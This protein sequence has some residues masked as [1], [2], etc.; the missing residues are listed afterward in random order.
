MKAGILISVVAIFV[1]FLVASLGS[2]RELRNNF[3]FTMPPDSAK[4]FSVS[5]P[6]DINLY[7]EDRITINTTTDAETNIKYIEVSASPENQ[8]T[9]PLC[10]F[11]FGRKEGDFSNYTILLDSGK[12]NTEEI[13]GGFCILA[14]REGTATGR[15]PANICDFIIMDEKLFD[16]FFQYGDRTP[17]KKETPGK[18]PVRAYSQN[19]LDLE[20]TIE[21]NVDIQPK[22]QLIRLEAGKWTT[23]EF[24]AP[25]LKQGNYN[26]ELI[27]E[28]VVN[29]TFCDSKRL[30]FCKKQISSTLQVDTNGLEGWYF[31]VTPT[32]YAAY[33]SMPV[34]YTATIENYGDDRDF[35]V[36]VSLP[37]GL[38]SG[39]TKAVERV[40]A[41][42][43][44]DF[45][46]SVVPQAGAHQTYEIGF[47]ATGDSEKVVKSYLNF[48]DTEGRLNEYWSDIRDNVD[49][50]LRPVLEAQI[51]DFL[52]EYR[53]KGIDTEEY[54]SL[55]ELLQ[56]AEKGENVTLSKGKQE[57][58]IPPEKNRRSQPLNPYFVVTPLLA[59]VLII[60]VFFYLKRRGSVEKEEGQF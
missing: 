10:F 53:Q 28:V 18:I 40:P 24:E 31:Y 35:S 47:K 37:K 55:L 16:V 60:G 6:S 36:E 49:P 8:V 46:V 33:N 27:A 23:F 21:S 14:G 32:S 50:E 34:E 30:P 43:K 42:G 7:E 26:I 41:F 58:S 25:A 9:V 29:G 5:L 54:A 44:K 22:S 20:L 12:T 59:V 57:A 38:T 3:Y 1:F 13:K 56:K 19:K 15:P 4:C 17:L 2:A 11:S 48:R 51:R 45:V 39:F 52:N